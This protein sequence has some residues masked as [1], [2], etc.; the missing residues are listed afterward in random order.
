MLKKI[1]FLMMVMAISS[2]ASAQR[3][4][5]EIFP[6]SS[7]SADIKY[8]R[9]ISIFTGTPTP[10][11]LKM[12][13]YEPSGMPDPMTAR[14]LIVFMHTGSYIP[15]LINESP[16]GSR[17]DSATAELCRQFARRGYVVA[18]IDYRYGWNPYGGN[19]DIRGG[20]L[21]QA[22]YRS[23]Q[24]AKAAVRY[25]KAD[26]AGANTY[27]ID[28]N[29]IIL[30]GQG[31]GGYVA[32]NYVALHD[33]MQL[34][35]PGKF[36]SGTDQP[37]YDFYTGE[38]YINASHMGDLDGHGSI[39]TLNIDSNSNG[40]TS[41]VRFAFNL[42]GALGDSSWLTAGVAPMVSFHCPSDPFAPYGNGTVF[43]PVLNLPVVDVSG[44]GWVIPRADQLGN[45][46]CFNPPPAYTDPYSA[47]ADMVNGG[48]D[49][50]FPFIT[51]TP[52]GSPWEWF[53]SAATVQAGT[54]LGYTVGH[55]D[56]IYWNA[57]QTNPNMSKTKALNY[58]DTIMNYLNPR[59]VR[60]L[61]LPIWP[62][63]VQQ[64][65]LSDNDI[66]LYPNPATDIV[67]VK[68]SGPQ[69][70][71]I[72]VSDLTGRMVQCI[73]GRKTQLAYVNMANAS[74]GIYFMSISTAE[75]ML[76]KKFVLQ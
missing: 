30:G 26:A 65:A 9:N 42:G 15:A 24:D 52:E 68:S 67:Y 59:L 60:C 57:L 40:H 5:S 72:V 25:F 10:T 46:S 37:T 14:P 62:A 17:N 18:N 32:L 29:A 22:V 69:I 74:P 48:A 54:A 34:Q 75:G 61:G 33:T 11:D 13:V 45:N 49:G 7:V 47:R 35:I 38:C 66:D 28:S 2:F 43:V 70:N 71:T 23:V 50:L 64:T 27:K 21:L 53:D 4:L 44:S 58:I 56:T 16:T 3:F 63:G 12:D 8:G 19:Q 76:T 6:S 73:T 55:C 36:I 20:S 51:V 41:N 1:Y 39:P 31:T